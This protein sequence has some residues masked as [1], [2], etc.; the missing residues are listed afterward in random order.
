M[1]HATLSRF[2]LETLRLD[3]G[4]LYESGSDSVR[5]VRSRRQSG[6][7]DNQDNRGR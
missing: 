7:A 4:G 5:S 1:I 6:H 2:P 3:I